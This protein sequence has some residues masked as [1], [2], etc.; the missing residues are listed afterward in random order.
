ML[1]K[2]LCLAIRLIGNSSKSL[3][4][5]LAVQSARCSGSSTNPLSTLSPKK[6]QNQEDSWYPPIT[7]TKIHFKPA[8]SLF[9]PKSVSYLFLS[10]VLIRNPKSPLL[11]LFE[12]HLICAW[13]CSDDKNPFL[14]KQQRQT[15]NLLTYCCKESLCNDNYLIQP[16]K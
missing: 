9:Y 7:L 2:R 12:T 4:S 10:S 3:E 14:C 8:F 15:S 6:I 13:R 1:S 11:L 16:R 5:G